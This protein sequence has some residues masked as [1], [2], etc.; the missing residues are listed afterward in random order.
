MT[1]SRSMS[2]PSAAMFAEVIVD[3]YTRRVG[4]KVGRFDRVAASENGG[5]RVERN[6]ASPAQWERGGGR[7]C[8]WGESTESALCRFAWGVSPCQ[9]TRRGVVEAS[10][11]GSRAWRQRGVTAVTRAR[12]HVGRRDK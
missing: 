2:C 4:R 9:A 11:S 1:E 6:G 10:G 5:G 12:S 3:L 7:G 8:E